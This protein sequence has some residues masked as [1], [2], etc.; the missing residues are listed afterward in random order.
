M[1]LSGPPADANLSV[2]ATSGL[3][4]I[5]LAGLNNSLLTVTS[6]SVSPTMV[7][8][9]DSHLSHVRVRACQCWDSRGDVK[10]H[11]LLHFWIDLIKSYNNH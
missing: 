10:Y 5:V 9:R 8:H 2:S 1:S 3:L 6:S 11:V 4:V 7:S